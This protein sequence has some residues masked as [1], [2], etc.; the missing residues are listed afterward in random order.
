MERPGRFLL[1]GLSRTQERLNTVCPYFTMFPLRFPLEHLADAQPG[2]LVL[3]PFCGRGTTL[4]AAR[5]LGLDS[6]GIDANPVAAAI[7]AAKVADVSVEKVEALAV[8]LLSSVHRPEHVPTG[9]F[10]QWA[11][12][13]DTL[14]DVCL[15]REQLLARGIDPATVVLRAI[16]LGL[17]HGPRRKGEATY[18]SNQMPRT[19]ATKPGA[20]VRFW[21]AR[22][23]HPPYVRVLD[24]VRRRIWYTLADVPTAS[25]GAVL[26]G[27]AA[28]VLSQLSGPFDW[29]VTSPPYLGMRTYVP[30]QWVRNWFL[31]GPAEVEYS[32]TDQLRYTPVEAFVADLATVWARLAD[33]CTPNARMAIR[34]GALPSIDGGSSPQDI[35][36]RSLTQAAAGWVI[37]EITDAGQPSRNARQATQFRAAGSYTPE[38]DCLVS[39][40]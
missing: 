5:A 31:G 26:C 10:W 22:D 39:R 35:L 6:V 21:R 20:A 40:G 30:D 11:Y 18:L 28:T 24:A 17:L 7:A 36:T 37:N 19:Y 14:R 16:V 23:L 25:R 3:D 29:V 27:D 34:F 32:T 33:R 13:P 2:Q 15:L 38:I 8:Q 1:G 4:Y 12:H 9:E